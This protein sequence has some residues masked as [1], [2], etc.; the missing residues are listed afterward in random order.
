MACSITLAISTQRSRPF[1][2]PST[3]TSF[4]PL[5]PA[6]AVPPQAAGL[7][8]QAKAGESGWVGDL[9]IEPA[10]LR[11]VD[12]AESTRHTPRVREGV[13]NRESHVGHRQ[14]RDGRPIRSFDHRVDN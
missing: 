13:A 8:G 6:G 12:R 10:E 4:A 1:R 11:P 3:A 2:N 14:L 9:K 5:R 7:V